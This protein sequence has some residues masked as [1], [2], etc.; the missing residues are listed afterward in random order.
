MP[1]KEPFA[2]ANLIH[3]FMVDRYAVSTC[4]N[5]TNFNEKEELC[6]KASSRPPAE[7]LVY[8]C[9]AWDDIPF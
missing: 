8:G 1:F 3:R 6:K 9:E 4:L 2:T 7:V 5:C